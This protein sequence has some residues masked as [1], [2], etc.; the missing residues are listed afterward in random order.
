[1]DSDD[2]N[3]T[4]E[5][6]DT[7]LLPTHLGKECTTVL[8]ITDDIHN[9]CASP[10]SQLWKLDLDVMHLERRLVQCKVVLPIG[11]QSV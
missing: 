5:Q 2:E 1:M 6:R 4:L 7:W 3:K 11:C 10:V 8:A 9:E